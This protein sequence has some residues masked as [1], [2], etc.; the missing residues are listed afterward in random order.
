MLFTQFPTSA[1]QDQFLKNQKIR[2]KF[3]T[4]FEKNRSR[5]YAHLIARWKFWDEFGENL[6]TYEGFSSRERGKLSQKFLEILQ[7]KLIGIGTPNLN[8]VQ[9]FTFFLNFWRF[10]LTY[11]IFLA[12]VTKLRLLWNSRLQ[13]GVSGRGHI[14]RF[15][16]PWLQIHN[17][18]NTYIFIDIHKGWP[19]ITEQTGIADRQHPLSTIGK[20][21][22]IPG[23]LAFQQ[24]LA[25]DNRTNDGRDMGTYV[26]PFSGPPMEKQQEKTCEKTTLFVI[27]YRLITFTLGDFFGYSLLFEVPAVA[28]PIFFNNSGDG[29]D[30][31]HCHH[32]LQRTTSQFEFCWFSSIY[33]GFMPPPNYGI[34]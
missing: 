23:L 19:R 13:K 16:G 20:N 10:Y 12:F 24:A 3:F 25:R 17:V 21:K 22:R 5:F 9:F 1:Y 27:S 4:I 31:G 7:V 34:S 26:I 33:K 6:E 14:F 8:L 28:D 30:V 11:T 29:I 32:C 18:N 15:G 2:S